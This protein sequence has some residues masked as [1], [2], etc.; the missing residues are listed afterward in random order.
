MQQGENPVFLFDNFFRYGTTIPKFFKQKNSSIYCLKWRMINKGIYE[1]L[2]IYHVLQGL[3]VGI[4]RI[5]VLTILV[6][7]LTGVL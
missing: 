3:Q 2:L 6:L 1:P 4:A 5:F 7:L